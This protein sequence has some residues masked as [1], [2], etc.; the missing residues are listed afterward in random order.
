MKKN[1]LYKHLTITL[2][3]ILT[4]ATSNA[5]VNNISWQASESVPLSKFDLPAPKNSSHLIFIR[6]DNDKQDEHTK[7]RIDRKFLTSLSSNN[8]I[9]EVV[10]PGI[11]SITLSSAKDDVSKNSLLLIAKNNTNNFI[12]VNNKDLT[13]QEITPQYAKQIFKDNNLRLQTHQISR[14]RNQ[15]KEGSMEIKAP[16]NLYFL[17]PSAKA[18]ISSA[19]NGQLRAIGSFMQINK[20]VK[21]LL[22]GHTDSVDT[23]KYNLALSKKRA[24]T[25]KT[26]LVHD[27]QI[28]PKRIKTTGFGEIKPIDTNTTEDGRQKNR[29][30]ELQFSTF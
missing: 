21:V 6:A 1:N 20:Q 13:I 23:E 24:N 12:L 15:C 9:T 30:V 26:H 18:E 8:Y 3:G 19:D 28:D 4:F 17:F 5:N 16:K 14:V 22:I 27:Y 2:L 10:C 29:R 25:V 11:H 7:I